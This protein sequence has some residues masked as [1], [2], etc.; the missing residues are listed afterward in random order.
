M[1]SHPPELA[2]RRREAGQDLHL[3][4]S[5]SVDSG[6]VRDGGP[7]A[8]D[9]ARDHPMRYGGVIRPGCG[10]DFVVAADAGSSAEAGTQLYIGLGYL[11]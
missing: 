7:K 4:L 9:F 1:T 11:Y 5:G 8:G 6:R 10:P 3:V 2:H